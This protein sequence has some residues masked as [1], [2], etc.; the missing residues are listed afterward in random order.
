MKREYKVGQ[1]VVF[2]DPKG[3]HHDALV[4]IWWHRNDVPT[5]QSPTGEPGCNL[6]FVSD[7]E[8]KSDQYGRQLE[9]RFTSVL[10]KSFQPAPGNYW[11]FPDE[12]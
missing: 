8:R 12:V 2:V 7:D 3:I 5:Y 9:E 10:H 4:T 1:H 6:V 11:M